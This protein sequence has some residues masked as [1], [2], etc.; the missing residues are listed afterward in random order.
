MVVPPGDDA[1]QQRLAKLGTQWHD[2]NAGI[3]AVLGTGAQH[4]G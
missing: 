4:S 1:L 2:Q 3:D